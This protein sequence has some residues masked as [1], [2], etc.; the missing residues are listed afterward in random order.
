MAFPAILN[1]ADATAQFNS[2]GNSGL[3]GVPT[4]PLT[5]TS[6]IPA[7]T[8]PGALLFAIISVKGYFPGV[9]AH[10]N[11]IDI[12][13]GWKL[14]TTVY[15]NTADAINILYRVADGTEGA[16]IT[17]SYSGP[18]YNFGGFS[19]NATVLVIALAN[20]TMPI[21]AIS[22]FW[23]GIISADS[24][25]AAGLTTIQEDDLVLVIM[26]PSND[27]AN[28]GGAGLVTPSDPVGTTS[29]VKANATTGPGNLTDSLAVWSQNFTGPGPTGNYLSAHGW[30]NPSGIFAIQLVLALGV[31]SGPPPPPP[32]PPPLA[33]IPATPGE[34]IGLTYDP[35]EV[36]DGQ[37]VTAWHRHPLGRTVAG[38]RLVWDLAT[39]P[40]PDG[41]RDE[42]WMVTTSK[43]NGRAVAYI[44]YLE[45]AFDTGDAQSSACFMDASLEY[46][47]PPVTTVYPLDHLEGEIVRVLVDGAAHPDCV[48]TN[49]EITLQAPASV[50]QVGLKSCY[51]FVTLRVEAGSQTGTAQAKLKRITKMNGVR[52]LN[53]LG[54][55]FGQYGGPWDEFE[56]RE[57]DEDPMDAPPPLYTGDLVNLSYNGDWERNG[58]IQITDDGPFPMTIV[59]LFPE[60]NT[61]DG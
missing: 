8:I 11:P 44:E 48:V 29:V 32:P 52:L 56:Y 9:G 57:V 33:G 24:L 43:V 49:G 5:V 7:E 15:G 22:T 19:I 1:A 13:I 28:S 42:L 20:G 51:D 41:T 35:P 37:D 58:R 59:A 4:L 3:F 53:A 30:T 50:V 12:P 55:K 25:T 23:T 17:F 61:T 39:I 38:Q 18:A 60:L 14:Y 10:I 6:P 45:K 34:L 46:S 54:G 27:G 31:G 36:E 26:Q 47:G 40:A 16:N 21:D 2:T